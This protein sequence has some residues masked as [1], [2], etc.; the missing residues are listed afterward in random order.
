MQWKILYLD[1]RDVKAL[2]A[3]D[4]KHALVD[5]EA[6]MSLG[7][8]KDALHPIK[9]VM[10]WDPDRYGPANRI[11][12]MPGFLGG[13]YQMAGIKW[14]GSNPQNVAK[15]FPRASALTILNDPDNKLPL[16]ILDGTS[17][18]AARTGASG[19]VGIKYLAKKD[20]K[21]L[22]LV[23]AGAQSRTQL[24]AALLTRPSLQEFY[25]AD[26][27]L[28]RA[29]AFAAEMNK[30]H[31][32]QMTAVA[33]DALK[34]CCQKADI[35]ITATVATD[36]ILDADWLSPGVL[37]IQIGGYEA[38]Y[39][40]VLKAD[41]RVCD[42]WVHVLHRNATTIAYMHHDGVIDDSGI[43]ADLGEI[44]N[45][46]KPGR[47]TD[48]E[49]IY[50]NPVGMG[51]EDIAIATRLYRKAKAENVGLWLNYWYD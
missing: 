39:D 50:Y 1:Q 41:K 38:T 22:V 4:M 17:I 27:V 37:Y 23:G 46:K 21:S 28:D 48:E 15:G 12:S 8:K 44:C 29:Q 26:I 35:I 51:N 30:K 24:E 25:V 16:C 32:I 9:G 2:G 47:E 5:V 45:G 6:A 18:S 33:M 43:Y 40:A 11:N 36:P 10:E 13:E 14:I 7:E 31:S 20:A 3:E 19:G 49:I 42:E 34:P